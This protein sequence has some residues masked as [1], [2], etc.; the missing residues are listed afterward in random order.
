MGRYDIL[1]Q[2]EQL[3]PERDHVR[4]YYLSTG[5]D[6][7]WDTTRALELALYRTYCVP[8][9]SKLLETTGEFTHRPQRRYDDTSIIVAEISEFG[10]DSERGREALRRMNSI[11][12]RF[13]ISNDD[14]LYVLSTFVFVPIRWMQRFGWRRYSDHERLATFYFW[15]EVGKRM[16]IRDIPTTYEEFEQFSRDYEHAQFRYTESNARIGAATRDL[17]ASW[18]PKALSPL[19]RRSIHA[20]LDNSMIEA[21]GFPHPGN[22]LR[23]LVAFTLRTRGRLL[24]L[25]PPRKKAHF[26]THDPIRSYPHGYQVKDL[27]PAHDEASAEK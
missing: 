3:D 11:H 8:S 9:I 5:F 18:F 4:I 19:V 12:N 13:N 21:F 16:A 7:S 20:M 26:I 22:T 24:R 10:Y 15:R 14:F 17:F 1:R 6:F 2:I 23:R 25:L 27:G